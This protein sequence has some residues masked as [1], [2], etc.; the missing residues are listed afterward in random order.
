MK[1]LN[2]IEFPAVGA[3][4]TVAE[5]AHV[6]GEALALTIDQPVGGNVAVVNPS[7]SGSAAPVDETT[8]M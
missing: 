2:T 6:V 8:V 4:P 3:N 5:R 1:L 7:V